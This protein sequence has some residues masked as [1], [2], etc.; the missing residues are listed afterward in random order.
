M[1]GARIANKR[2]EQSPTWFSTPCHS[3]SCCTSVE[4]PKAAPTAIARKRTPSM[5]GCQATPERA[6][7]KCAFLVKL[8]GLHWL[9]A[10]LQR[11][12]IRYVANE[13]SFACIAL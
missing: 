5:A 4:A 9:L 10:N 8:Q 1:K 13:Y 3:T 11:C 6:L 12:R 7:E 2:F